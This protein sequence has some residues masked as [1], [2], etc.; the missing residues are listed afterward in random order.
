[1]GFSG[2]LPVGHS[3]SFLCSELTVTP[4]FHLIPSLLLGER[5]KPQEWGDA[6]F[7]NFLLFFKSLK[8]NNSAF[9]PYQSH[10]LAHVFT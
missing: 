5:G 8:F 7:V 3:P 4:Y 1:M 9:R 2:L 6:Y 10:I